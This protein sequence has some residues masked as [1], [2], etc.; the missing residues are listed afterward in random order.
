MR[1]A[2][3][4][5]VVGAKGLGKKDRCCCCW[6]KVAV[7]GRAGFV[8]NCVVN[9]EAARRDF[10]VAVCQFSLSL[11]EKEVDGGYC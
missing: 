9:A 1:E 8:V 3:R 11:E 4:D 7:R 5:W 2:L 6:V 10:I